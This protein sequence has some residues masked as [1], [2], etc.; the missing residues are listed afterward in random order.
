MEIPKG[1][2]KSEELRKTKVCKIKKALYGLRISSKRWNEKFTKIVDSLGLVNDDHDPCL[3]TWYDGNRLAILILYVDD[4]LIASNDREKLLNIKT[5]LKEAFEISDL[6]EHQDFL[7]IKI[8]RD[9]KTKSMTLT[10]T[11]YIE[12]ILEKFD[13]SNIHPKYTPMEVYAAS[14]K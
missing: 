3:F 7:G 2:D 9:R 5:K 8:R 11:D 4:M 13:F 6:G 1:V 12:R 10:Q 14:F